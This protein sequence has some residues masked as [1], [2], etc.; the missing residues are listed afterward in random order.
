VFRGQLQLEQIR[1]RIFSIA[2]KR[3]ADISPLFRQQKTIGR[4]RRPHDASAQ[5]MQLRHANL[6]APSI[7]ITVAFG[8]LT[9]TSTTDVATNI[10][11]LFP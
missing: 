4:M 6:S 9:P 10:C 11:I 7:M 8:T 1:R 3:L 2:R 5:L